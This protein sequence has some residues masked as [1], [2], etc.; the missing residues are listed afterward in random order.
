MNDQKSHDL[1]RKMLL[2]IDL[3]QEHLKTQPNIEDGAF[4]KNSFNG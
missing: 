4:F 3:A 2:K 1:I